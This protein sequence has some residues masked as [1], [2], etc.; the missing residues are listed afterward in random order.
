MPK[1]AID[2]FFATNNEPVSAGRHA[3]A[4]SG[5]VTSYTGDLPRVTSS[6]IVTCGTTAGTIGVMM[7]DDLDG[8]VVTI[9]VPANTALQIPIQIRAVAQ[10]SSGITV[11]PPWS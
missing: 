5:P 10:V 7:P 8:T 2:P 9:P 11:V 4:I 3:L 6:I 1:T